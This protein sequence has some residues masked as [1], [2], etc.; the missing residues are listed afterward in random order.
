MH[1]L[2][3][4]VIMISAQRRGKMNSCCQKVTQ[5]MYLNNNINLYNKTFF[6]QSYSIYHFLDVL[7]KRRTQKIKKKEGKTNNEHQFIT[8]T[9]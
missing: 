1:Y 8:T 5:S 9:L 6:P 7:S 3:F 2:A 4:I